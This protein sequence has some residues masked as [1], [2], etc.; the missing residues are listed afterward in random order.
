MHLLLADCE[1]NQYK[2][3]HGLFMLT[4]IRVKV[5]FILF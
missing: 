4:I 1:Y 5:L 3:K 2:N